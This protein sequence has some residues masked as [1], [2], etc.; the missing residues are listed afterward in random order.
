MAFRDINKKHFTE[1]KP[2]VCPHCGHNEA[3]LD[4]FGSIRGVR[5]VLAGNVICAKCKKPVE[6]LIE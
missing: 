5:R 1:P 2:F 3:Q 4:S 6:A